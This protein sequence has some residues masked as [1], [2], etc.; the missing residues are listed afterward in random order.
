MIP[1]ESQFKA[2]ELRKLPKVSRGFL[3]GIVGDAKGGVEV[4]PSAK[5]AN[6]S[7]HRSRSRSNKKA[8]SGSADSSSKGK[9]KLATTKAK[10]KSTSKVKR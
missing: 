5:K 1:S 10:K 4:A 9:K 2:S 7:S 3:D 6:V 8:G